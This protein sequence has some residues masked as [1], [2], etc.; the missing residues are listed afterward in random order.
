MRSSAV[1]L[2]MWEVTLSNDTITYV[3]A[4][5][6]EQAIIA[7]TADATKEFGTDCN[8]ITVKDDANILYTNIKIDIT[9][10]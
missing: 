8:V 9:Y 6:I 3:N 4:S 5:T 1:D 7:A 10:E 2:R